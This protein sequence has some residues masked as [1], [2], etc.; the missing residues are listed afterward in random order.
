MK[1]LENQGEELQ[2]VTAAIAGEQGL[3]QIPKTHPLRVMGFLFIF[4][5][6]IRN[7]LRYLL[8]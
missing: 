8:I 1:C 7:P 6:D 3:V 4:V 2:T 5:K